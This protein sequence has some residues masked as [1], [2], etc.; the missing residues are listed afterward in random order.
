MAS[1]ASY[2]TK[3]IFQVL[4][5]YRFGKSLLPVFQTD[6]QN[7]KPSPIIRTEVYCVYEKWF[8][9]AFFETFLCLDIEKSPEIDCPDMSEVTPFYFQ[10]STDYS[11]WPSLVCMEAK[12]CMK[13]GSF[14]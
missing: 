10:N 12:P 2:Q 8:D 7:L 14:T 4:F 1:I 6:L 3:F 5:S 13:A 9:L 11:I